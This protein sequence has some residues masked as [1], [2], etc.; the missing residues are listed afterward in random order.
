M[1]TVNLGNLNVSRFILGSNPFSGFSHQSPEMDQVMRRFFTT[2]RIKDLLFQAEGLGVN[3]LIARTDIHVMR[4]LLEYWDEGGKLQ[5]FAQTCPEIGDHQTCISRAISG[6][7]KACHIHGGV[8]DFLYAQNRLDEIPP[9]IN[10]IRDHGLQAGIAAHNPKVIEWAETN[11]DVDYYMCSY[12]NAAHRDERAEHVSGMEEWFVEED[13]QAMTSLITK[14]SR[15]AIH[16]KVLAAGRND[17]GEA[18]DVVARTMRPSDMV[19]VGIFH[20]DQIQ[21]LQQDIDHLYGALEKHQLV[22]NP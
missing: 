3:T 10:L 2:A 5:W 18:F 19:C 8:M 15:P 1:D 11:L 14:L 13:R 9:V 17:P 16:Y 21:M 7:A 6:G 4:F 22:V 20:R 12:Y